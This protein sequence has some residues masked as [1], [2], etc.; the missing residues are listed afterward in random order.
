MIVFFIAFIIGLLIFILQ[1]CV[2]VHTIRQG[3]ARGKLDHVPER[4]RHVMRMAFGQKRVMERWWGKAHAVIFYAFLVFLLGTVELLVEDLFHWSWSLAMTIGMTATGVIHLVQTYFAWMTLVAVAVLITRRIVR[5][6]E[7]ASNGDAWLILVLIAILMLSHIGV[8]SSRSALWLDPEWL[9]K[10]LPVS[11]WIG[12]FMN[13]DVAF[14][15]HD[16]SSGVHILAVAVFLIWIPMG[17]HLHILFAFP[18]LFCQYERYGAK[19]IPCM[20]NPDMDGYAQKLEDA[21]SKDIP[22]AEWPIIGA[23]KVHD[24]KQRL[25]MNALTC[26]RCQRCTNACPMVVSDKKY[27]G[28]MESQIR[29]RDLCMDGNAVLVKKSDGDKK[30]GI[31]SAEELW[32]CTQ[33]GACDRVCPVGNENTARIIDLRRGEVCRDRAPSKLNSLLSKFERS[34]NPWGYPRADRGA[35]KTALHSE[36]NGDIHVVLF[37]GCMGAYDVTARKTLENCAQ[38]LETNGFVVH[39]LDK[40]SCCGEFLRKLGHEQ[41]FADCMKQNLEEIAKISEYDSILTICP[42]C[43]N[44]LRNEYPGELRAKHFLE[45]VAER[46]ERGE[47]ENDTSAEKIMS[48]VHMPCGLGK[49]P[50]TPKR[51]LRLFR[52]LGLEISDEEAVNGHCCGGGGGQFFLENS[53]KI[54]EM[55]VNELLEENPDQISTCC[56]F[57]VQMLDSEL[58]SNGSVQE[59]GDI[60]LIPVSNVIDIC[61]SRARRVSG[62]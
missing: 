45:F 41:E 3:I 2:H 48:R 27:Q 20:D 17:K 53:R 52:E 30:S 46:W 13:R 14:L 38:W 58:K 36:N 23:E 19:P 55:R 6:K 57:C 33:C 31:I 10:C 62:D 56:P 7:I 49:V 15:V 37:A 51:L 1:V 32:Q 43:A 39:T 4:F 28:P 25:I 61:I 29:L 40:E 44:T 22:E 24:L 35:W 12:S 16:L 47:L 54:A 26:T 34:G 5:K 11:K 21:V 42:H 50:E 59:D 60:S 18:N 9:D 8:M